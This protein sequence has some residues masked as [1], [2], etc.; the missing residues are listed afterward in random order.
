MQCPG[1]SN[2]QRIGE[3]GRKLW[4]SR[5]DI[6]LNG[7]LPKL[8]NFGLWSTTAKIRPTS[9]PTFS[10]PN[11]PR[12]KSSRHFRPTQPRPIPGQVR[13]E[14]GPK[15]CRSAPSRQKTHWSISTGL[16]PKQAKVGPTSII[17][18]RCRPNSTRSWPSRPWAMSAELGRSLA[19]SAP[20]SQASLLA[21]LRFEAGFGP[22]RAELGRDRPMR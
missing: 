22:M 2:K 10:D 14:S 7:S 6:P 8:D 19:V 4:R 3:A 21:S 17:F 20:T 12:S 11:Q 5:A 1:A 9:P 18:G 16:D 13:P 15:T